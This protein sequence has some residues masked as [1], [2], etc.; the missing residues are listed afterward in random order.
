MPLLKFQPSYL[1]LSCLCEECTQM[2]CLHNFWWLL[3]GSVNCGY[4]ILAQC[5]NWFKG[6]GNNKIQTQ[7][8]IGL[9]GFLYICRKALPF[10]A[11][12][13]CP[14]YPSKDLRFKCLPLLCM[15]MVEDFISASYC[16][17]TVGCNLKL[18][19]SFEIEWT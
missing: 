3:L 6:P 16:A 1:S 19:Y 7:T 17:L 18:W 9:S 13:K 12:I 8:D 11:S 14:V 2:F 15:V 10:D 5:Q 4:H